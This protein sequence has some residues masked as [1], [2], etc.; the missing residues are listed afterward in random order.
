[1][2][3]EAQ[4]RER[5]AAAAAAKRQAALAPLIAKD[6][7]RVA[8][9]TH[10]REALERYIDKV[11]PLPAPRDYGEAES[12]NPGFWSHYWD[13]STEDGDKDGKP[14]LD[15]LVDNHLLISVP[16]DPDNQPSPDGTPTGG[17][18]YV[19]FVVPSEEPYEGGTCTTSDKRWV[20]ML[21]ITDLESED[22]R[23]P[24][25]IPGSGCDCLWKNSPN[26]FQ[27]TFDY[28]VCGTFKR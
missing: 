13:V 4:A 7:R 5:E 22:T 6:Q 16:V 20:Y 28:V 3:R 24:K 11:G 14:F 15:F 1:Q 19:Y 25:N 18:Q 27:H 12:S 8:D 9:I 10:I 23:P 2:E 21:A 17:K 26:F